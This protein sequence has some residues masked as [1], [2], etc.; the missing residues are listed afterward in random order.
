MNMVKKLVCGIISAAVAL[1]AAS[2][3]ATTLPAGYTKVAYL[4]SH[5]TVSG[6][7]TT[8][9]NAGYVITD[10][11]VDPSQDTI[12]AVIKIGSSVSTKTIWVARG[13]SY[14][15]KT[16]TLV[17]GY[18]GRSAVRFDYNDTSIQI[19][20]ANYLPGDVVSVSVAG[21][22]CTLTKSGAAAETLQYT[23]DNSFTS[24]GGPLMFFALGNYSSGSYS[25]TD[26]YYNNGRLYSFT[27][28]RGGVVIHDL[29]P[30]MRDSDSKLGLYD[31]VSGGKFYPGTGGLTSST[32]PHAPAG[33]MPTGYTEVEYIQGDGLDA[34]ILTD[35][36]PTPNYDKIEAVVE[37][38]DNS[39]A[40][41]SSH[42]VWCARNNGTTKTW[43]AFVVYNKYRFDYASTQSDYLTPTL[44]TGVKYTITA[45]GPAFSSSGSNGQTHG[46]THDKAADFAPDNPLS[47]FYSYVGD[48]ESSMTN[49]G[50][51]KLYSFK[52]WRSG[53]LIH[54][55]VPCKNPAGVAVMVDL[56]ANPAELDVL[57]NFTAGPEGHFYEDSIFP[58]KMLAIDGSPEQYGTASPTYGY[59]TG[60]EAG[61]TRAVSCSPTW[62][63]SIGTVYSCTGWKLYDEND[64][65]VSNGT[66]TAFTYTHPTPAAYRRLEWQWE[67]TSLPHGGVTAYVQD[68]LIACWD[69]IENAGAG[70]H[71]AAATVWK[72]AIGG[73]EFALNNTIVGDESMTF[74]GEKSGGYITSYG[75]LSGTDTVSTF[76]AAKTG[77]VEIVYR[78]ISTAAT[79]VFLQAPQT[80]GIAFGIYQT[81]SFLNFSYNSTNNKQGFA[82]TSGTDVNLVSMRYS[83]SGPVSAIGNGNTLSR[84][85]NG[86]WGT[87]NASATYVGARA[88]LQGDPFNGSIY[89]IRLY[90]RQLT[91]EEIAANQ[92]VDRKRFI[93]HVGPDILNVTTSAEGVGSPSPAYG[94]VRGL[95]DGQ[96]VSV[97][98]G[99]AV[100]TNSN[101]SVYSCTGWKIYDENSA[102]VSS[103]SDTAFTYT[104]PTPAAYRELQW[105]WEMT[106][107]PT[108]YVQDGLLAFWDGIQNIG[109]GVH[110]DGT[111]VWKDLVGGYE[112]S[113][114]GTTIGDNSMIFDGTASS[115][116]T[117]SATDTSST[118]LAAKSGTLEIVYRS[119]SS[120][121]SQVLMQSTGASGLAYA[122]WET[123]KILPYT[124]GSQAS[125]QSFSFSSGT[126]TNFVA[127]RYSSSAPISAIANGSA[128]VSAGGSSWASPGTETFIGNRATKA[129]GFTGS[130]YAIRLYD[131]QLTNPEILANQALD[132]SR[133][134][135]AVDNSRL[136]ISSTPEGAGKPNPANGYLT[137]LV[138]GTNFIVTCGGA[139]DWTNAAETIEYSCAGWRLYDANDSIVDSGNTLSF[140]YTHP[141]PAAFRRLEWVWQP[142][143][144]KGNVVAGAGGSVSPSG[145]AWYATD[146][147][148]TV[149]ATP[150]SGKAFIDWTGTL[151]SGISDTSASVTFTPTAPFE[152]TANFGVGFSVATT[153]SDDDDGSAEHPFATIS[154]AIEKADAAI[155]GG[156]QHVII[157]VA[158]GSYLENGLVV[159]NA[160]VIVGNAADRTAVKIGKSG[161]RVFRIAHADA[162]LKNLTVQNGTVTAAAVANAGGNV[163]L[164][165][166][167]VA[168]C[169]LTGGGKAS[170]TDYKGGNLYISAGS[171]V[172]CLM[173][174][175]LAGPGM[176]GAN[177]YIA[178]GV[179][180]RCILENA[181]KTSSWTALGGGAYLT[182]GVIENCI[183]RGNYA[184]RGALNLN[185]SAKAINCTI[186]NNLPESFVGG[187]IAGVMITG[188][189]A[190]AINCVIFNNGGTATSEWANQS[191]A[192]F[193]NCVS[194][195][196]NAN[197]VNWIKL[198]FT[199]WSSYFEDDEHW[200]PLLGT[201][202][203]DA[204]DDSRYPSTSSQT[205]IAGNP[206]I[207]GRHID[208][209][210]S[211]LDQSS[212]N[213]AATVESYPSVLKGATVDFVCYAAGATDVV[214][215]ELDFGDGSAH[216][217]TTDSRISR[218]FDVAGFFNVRIRG[219]EGSG[220]YGDWVAMSVPICVAETDIYVSPEGND[221]NVGTAAAPFLTVAHALATLTNVS[222]SC[223]TDV[224]GVTVHI[225]AGTYEENGLPAIASRVTVEG[226]ASDRTAVKVGKTGTRIFCLADEGAVLRNLTVQNG[227]VTAAAETYAGGNVR[228]E[229]GTV[230]NCVLTGGGNSSLTDGKG[231]NL[232]IGGGMAV[233]CLLTTPV[234]GSGSYGL[235]AYITGGVV[236]RCIIENAPQKPNS[237]TP[238]GA[239]AYLKGGVIENCLVRGNKAGRGAIYLDAASARAVNCTI[240]GNTAVS[241]SGAGIG[242]VYVNN[243]SALV[244]NCVVYNNGGTALAEWGNKNAATFYSCAFSADAAFTGA[245]STVKDLTDAA[246]KNAASGNYRPRRDGALYNAGDNDRYSE[247]ATSATDLDGS[248]RIQGRIVDIGCWEAA[249]SIGSVYYLR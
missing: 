238:L 162:A 195:V 146:T 208:I 104:H 205:D 50:K 85:N 52:V 194:T 224:D 117:L 206:R 243:A 33:Q 110:V 42:T 140:V 37:F 71:D 43:S 199:N 229:N 204:G 130:I 150:D 48:T 4:Q 23:K 166:G 5:A 87:P 248:Q 30:A 214:T 176:Y 165:A 184:G 14:V 157:N 80:S 76:V 141:T 138:A 215:Y 51:Q 26:G 149:A 97:S 64:A 77:T 183:L 16:L 20:Q 3:W 121:A 63:N 123:S 234:T 164:E 222:S 39:F 44:A 191:G 188:S 98:C 180:S 161:A 143:A 91:D 92:E 210:C 168:N 78:A 73:Y 111:N 213:V 119:T 65:V 247:Y 158:D 8:S 61:D 218:R 6:S 223:A 60:L 169:V 114:T 74:T 35:Y 124:S 249:T 7:S 89:C 94:F 196:D 46:Q 79:Q 135:Q 189:S 112:F 230:T 202:M 153:G 207:S 28:T 242:G 186:V 81:S 226:V 216:L 187:G 115:Y 233:D 75:V 38:P 193:F 113:L 27:I 15:D 11:F 211:E 179:V 236:S 173:T 36:V 47:L 217:V 12:D 56:C 116:G 53:K 69:G 90:S 198:P 70:Q 107:P 239:G 1:G 22:V 57:G 139:N 209:G 84:Q 120:A 19:S 182:G 58:E 131:R 118:F 145:T 88:N 18:N 109:S 178:G 93:L 219:R 55:F 101:G 228:L 181:P 155:A 125:Q 10:V 106:S 170:L 34:R 62:R 133:F 203:V 241:G 134:S 66:E 105:Q 82:F 177:A 68:G 244:V 24:T 83:D 175:P 122:I 136:V 32:A 227:T 21:N 212:F 29:V 190:S 100:V 246:F 40:N 152:M 17:Y 154:N 59:L 72:D 13:S 201:P 31:N 225:A 221:A 156:A 245:N 99:N 200:T 41:A 220:E 137:G 148:I 174:S 25:L 2:A 159:T 235:G 95:G 132:R 185:N 147:P 86:Y 171:A 172:D 108:E 54:Y 240:V 231:G 167:T 129:T 151:P 9:A 67:R 232:Y 126:S 49:F 144:V 197:G 163:R 102:L 45:D 237:Y 160:I 142:S 192:R 103:G 127:V 128:L 96:T